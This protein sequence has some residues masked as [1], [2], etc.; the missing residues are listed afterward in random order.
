MEPARKLTLGQKI[1][2][3]WMAAFH[4]KTPVSAK[5]IIGGGVLYGLLPIDV[6]PDL[7]PIIGIADD[8]TVALVTI[9]A[10]LHLS[11][12]IRRELERTEAA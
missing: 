10:F 7:L 3:A 4:K 1:R 2:I 12:A 9:L 6:I 5:M 11:K 8:A